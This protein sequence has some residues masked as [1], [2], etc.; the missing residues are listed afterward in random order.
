MTTTTGT[1]EQLERRDLGE[2]RDYLGKPTRIIETEWV[3]KTGTTPRGLPFEVV[4][5]VTTSHRNKRYQ[6]RFGWVTHVRDD[7]Y[8]ITQWGSDHKDVGITTEPTNRYSRKRLGEIHDE[9]VRIVLDLIDGSNLLDVYQQ[10]V[11][12]EGRD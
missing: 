4:V 2:G 7:M 6:S 5:Q 8:R 1:L 9:S 10:A 12:H 11:N 3:V